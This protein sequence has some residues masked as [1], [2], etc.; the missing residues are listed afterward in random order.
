MN[1]ISTR[2]EFLTH[3]AVAGLVAAASSPLGQVFARE[4]GSEPKTPLKTYRIPQTDL[5]VSRIAY[6]TSMIG[7]DE[8]SS[9]FMAKTVRAIQ[10]AYNNG[11]PFFD[12][13]NVYGGG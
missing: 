8:R 13:A 9:D 7:I 2:R 3:T 5:V 4:I 6:G 1:R 10:T 11:I 12:L